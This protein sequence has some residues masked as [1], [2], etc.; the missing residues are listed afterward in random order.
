LGA[1][2]SYLGGLAALLGRPSEAEQRLTAAAAL[3]ARA[4]AVPA[5]ARTYVR[6]AGGLVVVPGRAAAQAARSRLVAADVLA[7]DHGL[8][9]IGAAITRLRASLPA[10]DV[11]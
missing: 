11:A 6:H 2:D 3:E 8:T 1:V 5:L 7:A 10:L 9:G 4:H